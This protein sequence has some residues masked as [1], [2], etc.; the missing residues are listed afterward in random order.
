MSSRTGSY[1]ETRPHTPVDRFGIW[2]SARALRRHVSSFDGL[3]LGDFG[4]GYHASFVRTVLPRLERAVLVD[5]AIADDLKRDERVTAIEGLLPGAL[6]EV[7]DASLDV[8][9]C[10]NV[11]EHLWEPLETLVE[12]RR[13]VAPKGVCFV[14][15]PSWRGKRFLEFSAYRLGLSPR[16]EI[17]DHKGYY[18]PRELWPLLVRAGF[19]PH[20]ISCY[21]HKFGL[22]T[23][24]ACRVD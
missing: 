14:N 16:E 3:R 5:V 1:G 2:L 21:R 7:A 9:V 12:L 6:R 23:F 8:V 4:C 15:V 18:D 22:N 11:L 20:G 13:I 10:V 17:D 19:V 24:A